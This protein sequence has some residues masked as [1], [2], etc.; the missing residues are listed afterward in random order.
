MYSEEKIKQACSVDI[1]DY[2]MEN[3]ISVQSDTER[4][5]RLIDHDSC[6]IDRKKNAFFWNSRGVSGNIINFVREYEGLTFKETVEKILRGKYEENANVFFSNEPFVYSSENEVANFDK[7]RNYLVNE[8]YIDKD[9]VDS[10]HNKGLIKQD[11]HNNVL[12]LWKDYE[13]IMGCSE[14]GTINT[15]KYKHSTWKKIQKNSTEKYGFNFMTGQPKHLKFFES[16][17][18]ALSYA[19]LNKDKITDTW[20]VSMEGLKHTTVFNYFI[21]AKEILKEVPDSVSL[22]VDNDPGGLEFLEKFKWL[23]VKR[24]DGSTYDFAIDIP[25]KPYSVEKWDWNDQLKYIVK[26]KQLQNEKKLE[27]HF[28]R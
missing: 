4:Y 22:C 25:E 28:Q 26:Q 19:T 15:N 18:D 7:A 13:N 10:L 3:G 17:I 6:V 21:K 23:E 14:Q 16:S 2:C 12:F 8:R 1:V 9:L 20:F 11:K 27:Y 5:Y 24:K